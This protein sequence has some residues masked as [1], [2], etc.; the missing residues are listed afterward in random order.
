VAG[1]RA[2]LASGRCELV[3]WE[4]GHSPQGETASTVETLSTWGF[5]HL[6]PL[7]ERSDGP[8]VLFAPDEGFVGNVF[9]TRQLV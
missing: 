1:A 4:C 7:S 2:V 9:S 8:L 3:I 5:R 6:R